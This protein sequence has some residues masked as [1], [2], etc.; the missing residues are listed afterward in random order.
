MYIV[1]F[2][3]MLGPLVVLHEL[4]HYLVGRWFGVGA[5]AFSVGFGKELA[6]YT[7]SRGTRWKLSALPFGG[8]VQF[9]GDMNPASQP[10]PDKP[11][12]AGD[13][14]HATLWQKTL[15]VAAGPIM[16]FLVAIAILAS[17]NFAYGRSVTPPVVEVVVE[18]GA[19]A[20]AGIEVGDRIVSIDGAPVEDFSDVAGLVAPYPNEEIDIALERGSRQLSIPVT[21]ASMEEADRFGNT[22]QVGRIGI[23][24]QTREFVPVGPVE[25]VGLAVRQTGQIL[26]MMVTGIWQIISGRRSVEE[27]G[28]PITIAKFSGEQLS[29]GW[30]SF[31][32]FAALISINLAFINLLP[33]PALD[34]GHLA[35]YAVE[36]VRRKPASARSQELAFRTG[37][38]IVLALM[39]FVTVIDIAKLSF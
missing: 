29:L 23:G 17:F 28:G 27:L 5:E 7:D 32:T 16:N 3:A 14:Q 1:G 35:F 26:D 2:L 25:S 33:I 10:D 13:F 19:A 22:F 38:A 36:A 11:G 15:I 20:Q 8:Y 18:E 9:Q 39:L 37:M 24:S 4:G 30:Q 31:A 12:R 21:I 6:G 34:G